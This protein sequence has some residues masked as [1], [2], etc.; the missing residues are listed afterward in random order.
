MAIRNGGSTWSPVSTSTFVPISQVMDQLFRDSFL[1]PYAF[2][3]SSDTGFSAPTGT[4]LWENADGYVVQAA[5][6]GVDP[7]SINVV[8][9]RGVLTIQ[10]EQAITAPEGAKALWNGL[11]GQTRYRLTLPAHVD[12]DQAQAKYEQGII[13]ITLPKAASAKTK[14]IKV[15]SA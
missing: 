1:L 13:S 9:D 10:G 5:M 12:A 6:P 14:S 15:Q 3:G 2:G 7:A 4:N 11:R 8:V